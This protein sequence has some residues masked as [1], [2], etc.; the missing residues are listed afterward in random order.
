MRTLVRPKTLLILGAGSDQLHAISVARKMGVRV[1]AV[2]SNASAPGSKIADDFA[3]ISNRDTAALRKFCVDSARRGHPISGVLA[4]GSDIP[5]VVAN[6]T[7]FLRVP[8]P[9]PRTGEI[10]TDKFL[11]KECLRDSG[12]DVPWYALVNNLDHLKSLLSD[13][14]CEYYVMKPTNRS[15]AR[16]V[17]MVHRGSDIH[18][19][20]EL[21]CQEAGDGRVMVEEYIPGGQISTESIL[22][23]GR[24]YTPGFADRNY[25]FLQRFAPRFIENGGIHPSKTS[26][27]DRELVEELV[28]KAALSLGIRNGISKG[29]VVIGLDGLPRIIE[30]AARLSGGDFSASLIPLGTG[31]DIVAAAVRLSIGEEVKIG[32]LTEKWTRHIANRYFFPSPGRLQS[33]HGID[34][35]TRLPWVKKLEFYISPGEQ[36][37]EVRSHSDRLGVFVVEGD[38]REELED[39]VRKIYKMIRFEVSN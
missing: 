13:H 4:V 28:E 12:V 27:S 15:G 7:D 3:P 26:G 16:G 31:V 1:S 6:L 24:A 9:S 29:D 36:V 10:T 25:E 39:R 2:D 30:M 21:T 20:Y 23:N 34:E 8:G 19:L 18:G 38:S 11:M 32:D 35:V 37:T 14:G 5:D 17:F 33:I 22:L